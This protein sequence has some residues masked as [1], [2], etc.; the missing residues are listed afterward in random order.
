LGRWERDGG[1]PEHKIVKIIAVTL[2]VPLV[3][4]N[5]YIII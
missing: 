3:K 4:R 2:F 5:E 1:T